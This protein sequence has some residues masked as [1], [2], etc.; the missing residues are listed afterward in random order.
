MCEIVRLSQGSAHS[1]GGGGGGQGGARKAL[2]EQHGKKGTLIMGKSFPEIFFSFF[3]F[4]T[5]NGR[6]ITEE[7]WRRGDG[8]LSKFGVQGFK[9]SGGNDLGAFRKALRG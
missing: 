6:A 3:Q 1:R 9:M 4:D 8:Y 2:A 7:E 5:S